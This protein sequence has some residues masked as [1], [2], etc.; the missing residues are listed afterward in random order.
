[1]LVFISTDGLP[2]ELLG[3]HHLHATL[4]LGPPIGPGYA[5]SACYQIVLSD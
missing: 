2:T 4:E 5:Q 3:T 1:M